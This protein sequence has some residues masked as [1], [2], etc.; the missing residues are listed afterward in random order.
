M[1][2][3]ATKLAKYDRFAELIPDELDL[4]EQESVITLALSILKSRNSPGR[5]LGKPDDSIAYLQ[6]T[7]AE[8]SYEVFGLIL[9]DIHGK[10]LAIEELFAGDISGAHVYRRRIVEIVLTH[11]AASVILFHNHPSGNP[12]PS[13]ADDKITERIQEVL[14]LIDVRVVDHIVVGHQGA[15][16]YASAGKI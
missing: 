2:H 4:H 14:A 10:V 9:L 13:V 12:A 11:R 7:L 1:A 16:S 3:T 8:R 5:T 15:Y 6:L